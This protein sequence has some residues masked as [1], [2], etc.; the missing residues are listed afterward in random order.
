MS[1]FSDK[2]T[3]IIESAERWTLLKAK[4]RPA[5]PRRKTGTP[6]SGV[7][8]RAVRSKIS[9]AEESGEKNASAICYLPSQH[10]FRERFVGY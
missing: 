4:K 7:A 6:H 10:A 8:A 5:Y 9:T 3:L 1:F 2:K